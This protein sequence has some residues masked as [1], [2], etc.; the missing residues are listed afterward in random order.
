MAKGRLSDEEISDISKGAVGILENA[1]QAARK[2]VF[3][4]SHRYSP[5]CFEHYP[6]FH[7]GN[8]LIEMYVTAF[9]SYGLA[10]LELERSERA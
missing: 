8:H 3:S 9:R 1:Y 6:I 5:T 2:S 10:C 4:H 7:L